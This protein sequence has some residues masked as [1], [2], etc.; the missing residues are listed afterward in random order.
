MCSTG[1][2]LNLRGIDRA[3]GLYGALSVV[4]FACSSSETDDPDND[5]SLGGSTGAGGSSAGSPSGAGGEA[6]AGDG[7]GAG[8]AGSGDDFVSDV[9]VAVHEQ[10]N[11]IL[12]VTWNQTTAADET[13]LEFTFEDGEVLRSRAKP[14]DLGAHRDVVLG[15]PASTPVTIRVVSRTGGVSY[16]TSD[17]QGTTG[18]LPSGLP[19]P[20]IMSYDPTRASPERYLFAAVE[21]SMGGC[22]DCYYRSIYWTYIMD[23]KGRMVWYYA[24]PASNATS[25]FQRIARDGEYILIEK[26][27]WGNNGPH[28]VLKMTLDWEYFEEIPVP[29]L[30]DCIDT[31][32]DG[33]LLYNTSGANWQLKEMFR[34]G[35]TRDIW[36]CP[37]EFGESFDC[38][39]NTVTWYPPDNTIFTSFVQ[40][41]TVARIDRESGA[42]VATYGD[43][44]GSYALSPAGYTFEFPHFPNISADG[45]LMLSAHAPGHE[46]T[47]TPTAGEHQFQEWTIDSANRT[48]TLKWMY[49]LGQEWAMYKGMA[50]KLAN[51]NVLANYGSGGVI[52]EITQDKETVFYVKFD[53]PTGDDFWNKMLGNNILIDDLYALNGGP[54]P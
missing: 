11:T 15:V 54:D 47:Y 31:T 46:D 1:A 9:T 18:P 7:A 16:A 29:D 17:Y 6:D 25:S 37:T 8:G 12:V 32:D 4:T 39:T 36:S 38:Y 2:Q 51:G 20:T 10:V 21:D 19:V 40:E 13:L 43:F 48:L 26:R 28:A 3:L 35:T 5:A 41:N 49:D 30:E 45:T 14:G 42:L 34:D 53:A 27:P 24:D 33:S 50:M 23:R 22:S 44:P 52:R